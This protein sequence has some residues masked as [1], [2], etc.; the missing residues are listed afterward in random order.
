MQYPTYTCV[1]LSDSFGCD[2]A[3]LN[4]FEHYDYAAL[5]SRILI[6]NLLGEL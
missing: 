6:R 2:N 3:G 4:M 5:T 1:I